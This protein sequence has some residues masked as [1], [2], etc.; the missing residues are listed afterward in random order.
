MITL[1]L[2]VITKQVV[3]SLFVGIWT[4]AFFNNCYNPITSFCNT[5]SIYFVDAIASGNHAPVVLFALVLGG[6]LE[7]VDKSGGATGLA[8]LAQQFASTRFRALLIAWGLSMFI[9]FDD[10]SCILIVG[11]TLKPTLHKVKVSPAKLAFI[12]QHI[13]NS[14]SLCSW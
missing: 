10:Y 6:V 8:K 3:P 1:I 5:F 14:K 7:L 11:A 12:I 4:G 2:A 13:R 9:F